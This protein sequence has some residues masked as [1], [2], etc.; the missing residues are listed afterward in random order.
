M[1]YRVWTTGCGKVGL[2]NGLWQ[3]AVGDSLI[4][5]VLVYLF[6]YIFDFSRSSIQSIGIATASPTLLLPPSV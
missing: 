5:F 6:H 4:S 2:V 1:V 3:L